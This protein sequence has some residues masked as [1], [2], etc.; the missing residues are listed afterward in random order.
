MD[1]KRLILSITL[2][3]SMVIGYRLLIQHLIAKHPS[4]AAQPTTE[5]APA[6]P[7]VANPEVATTGPSTN[8]AVA[9]ASA[10]GFSAGGT[11]QPV[12]ADLGLDTAMFPMVMSIDPRGAGVK[13]ITL[14][15]YFK[16]A[17]KQDYYQFEEP[18]AGFESSTRALATRTITI[19]GT[20]IDVSNVIW[21]QAQAGP[22]SAT[23][24]ATITESGKPVLELTKLFTLFPRD[25]KD[26]SGGWDVAVHQD[27]R[28]LTTKPVKVSAVLNGPTP[29]AREND[30]SED[31]RYVGGYDNGDKTLG[32]ASTL[33]TELK[34]D[35]PTKDMTTN[36]SR[37]LLWIGACNSYFESIIRP[38]AGQKINIASV[39][40]APLDTNSVSAA[41]EYPTDL[42]VYTSDF[43]LAPGTAT[44][45]DMHV[46]FGP[47]IRGLLK[48]DYYSSFPLW[49]D[50]TL[51]YSSG[52]C[53]YIT[54]SWLITVLS[55]ILWFFDKIFRDWG[56]AI[57]GLVCLVRLILHPIT[58]K[59]QINM[60][61]MGKMGPE[62]ERLKK[63]YG[64]NKDELNK[65]MMGVYKQQGLTPVLGCLPMFL[66]TPIW[67]ALWSALQSTFELRQASFLQFGHVHLTWISDLSHPDALIT[68]STPISILGFFHIT[69]LNIL[70]LM[71]AVV[72]YVQYAMQPV[73]A[74]MTPEQEQQRKMMKWMPLLFPVMLYGR[75]SGLSLYI[76]TSTTIGI[77][78]NKIIRDH[79]KK[80][81]EAEKSG[82]IIVS[83]APTRNSK[84]NKEEK[85]KLIGGPNSTVKPTGIAGFLASL[86]EKA[87]EI[88]REAEKRGKDRA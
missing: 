58:K 52:P 49:Y 74:N 44:P 87:E 57:I 25:A 19:D 53:G 50:Q 31:R 23:Y 39:I 5:P 11:T 70:P 59:S 88:R 46:F 75:P 77:I 42:S 61:Q 43:T 15:D 86:Q 63:K 20:D 67:I 32:T 78:E 51:V 27:F 22:S 28:N 1:T 84:K 64:D 37:P 60:L 6:A 8:P 76:V 38:D 2:T 66:Q 68:F 56:L 4:W 80:R 72:S 85:Q 30:L 47:K 10:N 12:T 41:A 7:V 3:L 18:V 33:V 26:G 16:T 69:S 79:I 71:L 29:P 24:T 83:A 45:L 40:A 9:T 48:N 13:S 62:I 36:D 14:G 81:D 17:A 55:G 82:K 21:K 73:P 34:K 54:F 35:K 65:A